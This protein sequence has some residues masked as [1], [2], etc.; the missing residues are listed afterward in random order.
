[1]NHS[2]FS[3][4]ALRILLAMAI[5]F[6]AGVAASSLNSIVP[7]APVARDVAL[8]V[9]VLVGLPLVHALFFP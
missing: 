5:C 1:M 3:S 9:N 7:P 6:A 2:L 4:R 8:P